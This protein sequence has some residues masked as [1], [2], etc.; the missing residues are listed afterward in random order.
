MT[1]V[2][3]EFPFIEA[4]KAEIERRP[5]TDD[6]RQARNHLNLLSVQAVENGLKMVAGHSTK[7]STPHEFAELIRYENKQGNKQNFVTNKGLYKVIGFAAWLAHSERWEATGARLLAEGRIERFNGRSIKHTRYTMDAHCCIVVKELLAVADIYERGWYARVDGEGVLNLKKMR[8]MD[9]F[10]TATEVRCNRGTPLNVL[11][12]DLDE[13]I[14]RGAADY[15]SGTANTQMSQ[16]KGVLVALGLTSS[17]KFTSEGVK[18][19]GALMLDLWRANNFDPI[20][21]RMLSK[22][23]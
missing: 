23:A 13:A 21:A 10:H 12:G 18:V 9:S 4:L 15:G 5:Q 19:S 14:R 17:K 7:F 11:F 2:N 1:N 16:F 8:R 3:V 20:P 22:G 6:I